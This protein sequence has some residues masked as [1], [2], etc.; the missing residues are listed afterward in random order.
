MYKDRP[1]KYG[2]HLLLLENFLGKVRVVM[3]IIIYIN[4][5]FVS[6]ILLAVGA[7]LVQV[8][9]FSVLTIM[10]SRYSI[11]LTMPIHRIYDYILSSVFCKK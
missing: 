2:T 4:N 3:S 8:L 10:C 11:V 7:V 5:T 6:F 9:K 1:L